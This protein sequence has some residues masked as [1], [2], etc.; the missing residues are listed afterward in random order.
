VWSPRRKTIAAVTVAAVAGNTLVGKDDL[1]WFK[2]L[3]RP[4]MQ[5]PMPV[6]AGVG[7][8]YYGLLGT[9]LYRAISRRDISSERLAIGVLFLNE[10]W[11]VVFF[12]TRSPR[13]GFL[14]MVGFCVPLA[15]LQ[16]SVRSDRT[17]T[18]V[19]APYTAWVLCYDLPW[20]YRLW[21]LNSG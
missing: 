20:T 16:R 13:N 3:R 4:R 17:S 9:V 19:L 14:G 12:K 11:N 21:L 6:F 10:A 2:G 8:V 7:A 15:L 1:A 18:V 5:I